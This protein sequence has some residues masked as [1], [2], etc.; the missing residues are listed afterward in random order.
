[1]KE[2]TKVQDVVFGIAI[3]IMLG[4]IVLGITITVVNDLK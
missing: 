3:F 1:M 4:I 2:K